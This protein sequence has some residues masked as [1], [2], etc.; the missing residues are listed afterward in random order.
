MTKVRGQSVKFRKGKPFCQTLPNF[1]ASKRSHVLGGS[2]CKFQ[3]CYLK[4]ESEDS[5]AAWGR[6]V[7]VAST[8]CGWCAP[9]YIFFSFFP[10]V[11]VVARHAGNR[12]CA[13]AHIGWPNSTVWTP[14][15]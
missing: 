10:P 3:T 8:W 11:T 1:T 9:N 4:S 2:T 6:K 14:G 12:G 13:V 15:G 5:R 7:L